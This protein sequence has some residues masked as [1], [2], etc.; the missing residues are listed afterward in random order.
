MERRS[1]KCDAA[2]VVCILHTTTLE[3]LW[4]AASKHFHP[5]DLKPSQLSY[6]SEG[7]G[8]KSQP[9]QQQLFAESYFLFSGHVA[10][11]NSGNSYSS[12]KKASRL[13]NE[14]RT[15]AALS[16]SLLLTVLLL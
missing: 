4:V 8:A 15:C 13:N 2:E 11:H 5:L 10:Q 7:A 1:C 3:L 16:G 9:K 12:P 14:A 6:P